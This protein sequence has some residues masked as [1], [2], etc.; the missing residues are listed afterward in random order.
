MTCRL[1]IPGNP[2][3]KKN[4]QRILRLGNGRRIL[5]PSEAFLAYQAAAGRYIPQRLRLRLDMP[6]EV[7]GLYFM[8]TRRKVDLG[9]LLAATCDILVHYGVL[10]DDNSRI[11][12]SHD[13]SRVYYDRDDPR[14]EIEIRE[15][16]QWQSEGV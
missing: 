16:A 4:S 3:T 8:Q 1:T 9:N 14:V 2:A 10:A 13:G 11:V 5:A 7:R 15:V 12:I 6:L